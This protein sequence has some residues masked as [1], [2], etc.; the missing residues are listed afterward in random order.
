MQIIGDSE[1][2]RRLLYFQADWERIVKNHCSLT[3]AAL[4]FL[5]GGGGITENLP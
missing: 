2:S 1:Y 5:W 4:A 3:R